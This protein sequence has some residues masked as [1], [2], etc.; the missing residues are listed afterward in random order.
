MG[1]FHCIAWAF[2]HFRS[3]HRAPLDSVESF[4]SILHIQEKVRLV[5]I[6]STSAFASGG[7]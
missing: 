4:E 1:Y 7:E 5:F 6:H 3:I 2:L